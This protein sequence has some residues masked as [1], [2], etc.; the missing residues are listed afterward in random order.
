MNEQPYYPKVLIVNSQSMFKNNA[1]GITLRSLFSGWPP[2]RVMEL[3]QWQHRDEAP[4][5]LGIV[6]LRLPLKVMPLYYALR[7]L[8]GKESVYGVDTAQTAPSAAKKSGKRVFKEIAA[9]V[10][11]VAEFTPIVFTER[12]FLKKVDDFSPDIIYTISGSVFINRFA[13]FFAKRYRKNIAVHYMDNWRETTYMGNRY[14]KIMLRMLNSTVRCVENRMKKGLAI[15]EKMA[16]EYAAKYQH[17]YEALMN[18]P[19]IETPAV[20]NLENKGIVIFAY[21]GGLHLGRAEQLRKVSEAISGYNARAQSPQATLLVYTSPGAKEK[22]AAQFDEKTTRFRDYLPHEQVHLIY[23]EAD[24]LV[25]IESFEKDIVGYTKYS[26]STKIPEYMASGKPILCCAP[27]DLA[28]T[29][30]IAKTKTGLAVSDGNSLREA[31]KA[32]AVDTGLRK[33]LGQNGVSTAKTNHSKDA[34]RERMREVFL[35]NL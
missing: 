17:R 13:V 3:Y 6:S 28:V 29:E 32:L 30:Y 21:A 35:F 15:S 7:K 11:M 1:T 5:T 10:R 31:V 27:A 23:A 33:R 22:L 24:V 20:A 14:A 12:S 4:N 19:D 18:C 8:T 26:L 34:A 9:L 16:A 2:G 25:H